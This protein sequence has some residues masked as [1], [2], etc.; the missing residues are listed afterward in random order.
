MV[1]FPHSHKILLFISLTPL[2]EYAGPITGRAI[3][4]SLISDSGA[5]ISI[6]AKS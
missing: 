5:S 1:G 4:E 2:N 3:S 6:I